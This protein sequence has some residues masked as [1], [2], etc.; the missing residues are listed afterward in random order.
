MIV[1][2]SVITWVLG[3]LFTLVAGLIGFLF[4]SEV[5]N[6]RKSMEDIIRLL[7]SED[8]KRDIKIQA[9]QNELTDHKNDDRAHI[10]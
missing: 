8:E 10:N 5:R 9:V 2:V 1:E 7:K 6:I 3:G 4:I